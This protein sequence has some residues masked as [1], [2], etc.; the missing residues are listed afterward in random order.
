MIVK[1][2][3]SLGELVDKIS[4]LEIKNKKIKDSSKLEDIKKELELLK[5]NLSS[6]DLENI[7]SFL[8]RLIEVNTV[9]WEIEDEIRDLERGK[10]F[11]ARFVEVARAVYVTND[12]RFKIKKE[13]NHHYGSDVKEVK[14]YKEY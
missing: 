14:S 6:L 3:V 4:I 11:G 1:C 7:A 13:I 10:D 9:L 8:E 12:E 5:N 2:P